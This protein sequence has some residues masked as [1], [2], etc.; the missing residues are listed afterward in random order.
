MGLLSDFAQYREELMYQTDTLQGVQAYD[1]SN[2][3]FSAATLLP[4]MIISIALIVLSIVA[5]WRMYT[6]AGKP[7][8]AAIVPIYNN[9][10]LSE[11][12]RRPGYWALLMFIPIVNIILMIILA[13]E[14]AKNFG[15][16]G[17][18]GL[19]LN[20]ILS[21][22]G[23]LILGFGKYAYLG[24]GDGST[25]APAP[26]SAA[27]TN[28]ENVYGG[29]AASTQQSQPVADVVPVDQS[30]M[31]QAPAATPA[32]QDLGFSQPQ[33][34]AMPTEPVANDVQSFAPADSV[35]APTPAPAPSYDNP[36][37]PNPQPPRG[38]VVG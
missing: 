34:P 19:F 35:L 11:I 21:P 30:F 23:Y 31:T 9:W 25:V 38:P 7:G 27:A 10:V 29:A 37:N 3:G 2:S 14:V 36:E 8:W 22:I 18:W 6:K 24:D 5:M 16:S 4:I 26:A 28:P 15:K 17:A 1:S 32:A 13:I 12:A 20:F 33:A